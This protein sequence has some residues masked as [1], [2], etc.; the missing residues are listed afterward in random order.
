MKTRCNFSQDAN[1][2]FSLS[3]G[4]FFLSLI[5]F[6]FFILFCCIAIGKLCKKMNLILRNPDDKPVLNTDHTV[7]F[8]KDEPPPYDSLPPSYEESTRNL[9]QDKNQIS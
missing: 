9:N 8:Q 5:A 4:I 6:L 7:D 1:P 3:A 2:I